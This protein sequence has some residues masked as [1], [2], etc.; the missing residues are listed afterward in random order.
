VELDINQTLQQAIIAHEANK[1]E[2]AEQLYLKILEVESTHPDVNSDSDFIT[3]CINLSALLQT[4]GKLDKAEVACRKAIELE[5]VNAHAHYNLGTIL[6]NLGKLQEAEKSYKKSIEFKPENAVAH[7]SLGSMFNNLD[8]LEEAVA[9]TNKAIKLKPD[10]PEA[11]NNLGIILNRLDKKNEAEE[12]FKKAI[13]LKFNYID[14][15]YNLGGYYVDLKKYDEAIEKYSRVLEIDSKHVDAKKNIIDILEHFSPSANN[16]NSII[17]AKNN[18]R[19][20]KNNFTLEYGIEKLEL[21][22]LFKNS[23]KIVQYNNKNL[24]TN[25]TQTF[26]RNLINLGCERHKKIFNEFNIIAKACFSCFKIQIE[27]KNVL[28]LFKLFFIFDKLKLPN[29]NIRKCMIEIR[30]NVSGSYKGLIY[31][32]STKE[33]NE[34]L[35]II[36]PIIKRLVIAKIKIK[37]GCTEYEYAFPNYK[38]IDED[39]N[40]FMKYENNW[41]KKEALFDAKKSINLKEEKKS[42]YDISVLDVLIMNNWLDYA[43]KINDLSYKDIS[44]EIF[45]SNYISEIISKQL[46]LRKKEFYHFS[47]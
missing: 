37:R 39:K 45:C 10:Y 16:T 38:E 31:C 40:N 2:E 19:K 13:K 9:S 25:Q 20:I 21:A 11:Y 26:R 7:F 30:P 29:N 24:T 1:F 46:T 15:L 41:E 42:L 22:N 5:P 47:I 35:R 4:L 3:T 12:S 44:D 34:I 33:A 43:K 36:F 14:A 18:L 27:P 32:S 17:V 6:N 28:E 8:R 23:N